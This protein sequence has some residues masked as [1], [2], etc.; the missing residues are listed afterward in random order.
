MEVAATPN[1]KGVSSQGWSACSSRALQ[2]LSQLADG[3]LL[4]SHAAGERLDL[5]AELV[6]RRRSRCGL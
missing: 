2:V 1:F 5:C 3:I 6:A 4:L